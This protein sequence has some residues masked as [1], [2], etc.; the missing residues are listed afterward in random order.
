MRLA[1]A[2]ILNKH[3]TLLNILDIEVF[4]DSFDVDT[5]DALVRLDS[6]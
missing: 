2:T 6:C 3:V 5:I 4:V 1:P